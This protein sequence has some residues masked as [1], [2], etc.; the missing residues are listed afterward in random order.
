[1][2]TE[3]AVP[4]IFGKYESVPYLAQCKTEIFAQNQT[5]H[6]IFRIKREYFGID[7]SKT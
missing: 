2:A 4:C 1:M 3:L 5:L 6:H 7:K